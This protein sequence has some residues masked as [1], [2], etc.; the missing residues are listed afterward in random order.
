MD[1]HVQRVAAHQDDVGGLDGHVGAGADGDAHVRLGQRRR[2]VHAVADHGH[3]EAARLHLLHLAAFSAG[4]TSAKYS[5]RP[6]SRATQR[7]HLA[8]VA[9]EH[10]A[11]GCPSP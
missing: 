8:V 7:G 10:H 5:S 3:D 11:V 1:G 4:S 9:G 2:V 6:I